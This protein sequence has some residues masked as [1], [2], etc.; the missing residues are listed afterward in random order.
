MCTRLGRQPWRSSY[1]AEEVRGECQGFVLLNQVSLIYWV[2]LVVSS[3]SQVCTSPWS[4]NIPSLVF[5]SPEQAHIHFCGKHLK[6]FL[7]ITCA[8]KVR[9]SV[10]QMW[11]P[12]YI[13]GFHSVSLS[14]SS[15][16]TSFPD[17][18]DCWCSTT[19]GSQVMH[20][21]W[22]SIFCSPSSHNFVNSNLYSKSLISFHS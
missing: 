14:L 12:V 15:H 8:N 17:F 16:Q 18:K 13:R 3:S 6:L 22:P 7:W 9:D 19:S 20:R 5:Q 10:R 2:A 4:H 1:H 21:Q 11:V